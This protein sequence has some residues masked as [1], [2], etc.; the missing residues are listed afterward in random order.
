MKFVIYFR[1][2]GILE[3]FNH[4]S[5]EIVQMMKNEVAAYEQNPGTYWGDEV[6]IC[7]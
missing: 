3:T 7:Q 1:V 6:I 2:P 5:P 4:P